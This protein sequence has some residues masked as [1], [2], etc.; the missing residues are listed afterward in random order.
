MLPAVGG[1]QAAGRPQEGDAGPGAPAH[2]HRR[3]LPGGVDEVDDVIADLGR[4]V[5]V[6]GVVDHRPHDV[7]VDDGAEVLDGEVHRVVEHDLELGV[8]A[9]VAHRQLEQEAVEL[10]LGQRERAGQLHRV[11]RGQHQ[12]RAGQVAGDT[13]D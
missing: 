6:G 2:G 3:V 5:D 12:E 9:H 1:G 8:A 11:L 13:V 10:G 4:D 7:G